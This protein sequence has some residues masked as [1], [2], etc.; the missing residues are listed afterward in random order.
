MYEAITKNIRVVVTPTFMTERSEPDE[1]RWFWSYRVEITNLGAEPV[2][3]R[4]RYWKIVDGQGRVQEVRGPGVVGEE[5]LIAPGGMYEY[6]SGCPLGTP[7]GFMV[8]SY[9]MQS[10]DGGWFTVEIP[11]FSLDTP[12]ELRRVN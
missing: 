7:T 12:D 2:R 1:R 11:A 9:Q 4:S 8:G 6:T 10:H 3:L 5:P